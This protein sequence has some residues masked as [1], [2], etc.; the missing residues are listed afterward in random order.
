M[1]RWVVKILAADEQ[2]RGLRKKSFP[3]KNRDLS[4]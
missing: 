1:L 2:K 4:G 3:S